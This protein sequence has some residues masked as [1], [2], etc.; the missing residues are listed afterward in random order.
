MKNFK[1]LVLF[2]R[3]TIMAPSATRTAT[4]FC[5]YDPFFIQIMTLAHAAVL[6]LMSVINDLEGNIKEQHLPSPLFN[7]S[8]IHYYPLCPCILVL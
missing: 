3:D 5:F 2:M 6:R 1:V 8:F 7:C 4:A